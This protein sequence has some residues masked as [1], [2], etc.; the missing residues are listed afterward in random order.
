MAYK[1]V[2]KTFLINNSCGL[3]KSTVGSSRL[4]LIWVHHTYSIINENNIKKCF[5]TW[6]WGRKT[7]WKPSM[8]SKTINACIH[9]LCR[10][11]EE[12]GSNQNEIICMLS[13][14]NELKAPNQ[15]YKKNRKCIAWIMSKLYKVLAV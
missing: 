10:K 5:L 8:K 14:I 7:E 15:K 6:N 1:Q 9:I 11:S 4:G 2:C 12:K 3:V 13:D